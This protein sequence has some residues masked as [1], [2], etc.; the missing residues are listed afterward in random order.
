MRFNLEGGAL[1]SLAAATLFSL[2]YFHFFSRPEC[3]A[4]HTDGHKESEK[5]FSLCPVHCPRLLPIG[6]MAGR[7][8]E[9]RENRQSWLPFSLTDLVAFYNLDRLILVGHLPSSADETADNEDSTSPSAPLSQDMTSILPEHRTDANGRIPFS[10]SSVEQNKKKDDGNNQEPAPLRSETQFP[11]LAEWGR[12]VSLCFRRGIFTCSVPY[13]VLYHSAVAKSGGSV[14]GAQRPTRPSYTSDERRCKSLK[15]KSSGSGK[16]AAS[17]QSGASAI[18]QAA[19][20][21]LSFIALHHRPL[22]DS[23]LRL[24]NAGGSQLCFPFFVLTGILLSVGRS[25]TTLYQL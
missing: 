15:G 20:H 18:R 19:L 2:P 13:I 24:L 4:T 11:S 14:V 10:S 3:G 1:R 7:T 17:L 21:R 6:Q 5:G 25:L 23:A 16:R 12:T 9:E 8:D 22:L